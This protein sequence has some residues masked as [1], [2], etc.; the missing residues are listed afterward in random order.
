MIYLQREI[1]LFINTD[2][3]L[4]RKDHYFSKL[5]LIGADSVIKIEF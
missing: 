1:N 5:N 3:I 2:W 4:N